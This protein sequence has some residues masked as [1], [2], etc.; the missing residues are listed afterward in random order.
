V[1]R[2]VPA[3]R[4]ALTLRRAEKHRQKFWRRKKQHQ[5]KENERK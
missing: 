5:F 3:L 4:H 2:P 1:F